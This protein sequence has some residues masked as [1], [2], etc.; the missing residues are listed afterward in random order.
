[1]VMFVNIFLRLCTILNDGL[2]EILNDV[3]HFISEDETEKEKF[4]K[5]NK[6]KSF[7]KDVSVCN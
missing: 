7:R 2:D 4:E 5:E 1:M 6:L 3:D